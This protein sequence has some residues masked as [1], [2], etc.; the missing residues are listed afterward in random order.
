MARP[1]AHTSDR[2]Y[3]GSNSGNTAND[4][5]GNFGPP[6]GGEL[7]S[8]CASA[9]QFQGSATALSS[10]NAADY[11]LNGGPVAFVNNASASFTVMAALPSVTISAPDPS[12][13]EVPATDTS[14]FRIT[15]TGCADSTLRVF[16]VI[17]GTGSNG[18]DYETLRG[19]AAIRAGRTSTKIAVRP[20]DDSIPESDET[21]ILKLSPNSN[22][23]IGLSKTATVTIH[24]NE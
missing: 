12:A 17:S 11:L 10:S 16:Y 7:T 3:T 24:S 22:Y 18:I 14:R 4:V 5:D 13:S 23:D 21:V 9:L 2:D 15:R 19:H 6:F 1:D 8:S 20:I